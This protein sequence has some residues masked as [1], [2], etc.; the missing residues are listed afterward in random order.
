MVIEVTEQK[1]KKGASKY[2][3]DEDLVRGC[4][5]EDRSFQSL[6]YEKYS[7]KMFAICMRYSNTREEA[8]DVLQDSFIKIFNKI[9][10]FRGDGPLE[11]WMRRVMVNTA[12]KSRDKRR[13]K[14]E[15]GDIEHAPE[16]GMAAKAI[17]KMGEK[18]ILRLISELPEGYKL[19]F[20]LYAVEGYSHKEIGAM[21][22]I[23]ESTS[24]SQYSRARHQLVEKLERLSIR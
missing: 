6:L 11:G 5:R 10:S 19:V 16:Q 24:R 13:L 3:S 4:M 15:S 7:N 18:D 22:D 14:F 1:D 9:S 2:M 17:S 21:L 12:L 23:S 20:N 8:E